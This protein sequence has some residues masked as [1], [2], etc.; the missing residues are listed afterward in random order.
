MQNSLNHITAICYPSIC[1][2]NVLSICGTST[3]SRYSGRTSFVVWHCVLCKVLAY[4]LEL[5]IFTSACSVRQSLHWA[6]RGDLVVL[7]ARSA[8]RQNRTSSILGPSVSNSLPTDLCSL[9]QELS[10]SFYKLLKTPLLPSCIVILKEHY[11]N[12]I[13]R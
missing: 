12:F 1:P 2:C 5:F 9:P 7:F 10:N 11:L 6:S 4:L 3:G 8:T 13:G